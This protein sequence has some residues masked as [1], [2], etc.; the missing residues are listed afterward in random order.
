MARL[1]GTDGVR[2]IANKELTCDLAMKI[3]NALARLIA[4]GKKDIKV[5]IGNDGRE[6]ADMLVSG[7]A[8]GLCAGGVEVINLG[9][10]PT[11]GCGYLVSYYGADAGIMITA[12][13]NPYNYNG[14]KIFDNK[15]RKLSDEL[16]DK[17]EELVKDE[18]KYFAE[19]LGRIIVNDR[20]IDDYVDYLVR[21]CEVDLSGLNIAVDCA[22]GASSVVAE[23]LFAR[24][25]VKCNIINNKPNGV[26]INEG[27][28]SLHIDVLADYVKEHNLDGGVA[29]D[30][31]A[32]RAIFV[33]D[34]G[35]VLDGDY[36][37]AMLG[38]DLA[39]TSELTGN[40][41]VGTVMSNLGL[42]KFC[43]DNNINFVATK[44]GDRYVLEEMQKNNYC[45][46]GE[47]SGHI[48]IRKFADTGD[49]E[50]TAI[51]VFGCLVKNKTK[52]SEFA[53][54]MNKYPQVLENVV[55]DN[56][57]KNSFADNLELK[58]CIC[59]YEQ[60]LGDTG[61]ILVRPSGTEPLIR[62]MIEGEDIEL[63]RKLALELAEKVKVILN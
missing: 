40:T 53:K 27:C 23:R 31:D 26:N 48:I 2:G 24:L 58:N 6:S 33:D 30:G 34:L 56:E 39:K 49:G 50:L 4:Y 61:R 17:I 63:I 14:I 52:F 42:I 11:P 1:F 13:H 59:E 15:G 10:I 16:E 28:G 54:I 12:S 9:I 46:G 57:K 8:S 7:L 41:I 29:F 45:L 19:K 51:L 47:Q 21:C 20:A 22:N 38:L 5:V 25:N 44:V 43:N 36:V 35:N 18:H 32:D 37:L 3:G 55:V 62:V 60:K